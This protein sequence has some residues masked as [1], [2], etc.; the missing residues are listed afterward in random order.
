MLKPERPIYTL[1]VG[2][3][4]DLHKHINTILQSDTRELN[5]A[6]NKS[7]SDFIFIDE[8]IELTGYKKSTVYTKIS[9]GEIPYV[10][11]KKPLTFSRE[12]TIHW[13]NNNKSMDKIFD[14][15]NHIQIRNNK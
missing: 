15:S 2:E 11:R 8:F 1:S 10:S 4:I 9:K 6:Q 7:S 5:Q 12:A 3:F 14:I 13:L